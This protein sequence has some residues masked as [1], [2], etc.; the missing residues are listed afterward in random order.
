[1]KYLK[2]FE[3]KYY[4]KATGDN[5]YTIKTIEGKY[6][7][8]VK[9]D[10]NWRASLRKIGI[11]M[12]VIENYYANVFRNLDDFR[13]IPFNQEDYIEVGISENPEINKKIYSNDVRSDG[14]HYRELGY[15]YMGE[16]ELTPED[17]ENYE[18]EQNAN[19]YNL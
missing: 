7:W 9:N 11:P 4:Y 2:K 16:V 15:K 19:K 10:E 17:I 18:I 8:T 13:I 12:N 14:V 6:F 3:G 1:M 5:E